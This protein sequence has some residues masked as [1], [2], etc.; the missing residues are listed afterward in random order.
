M[1]KNFLFLLVLMHP[2]FIHCAASEEL[3]LSHNPEEH[4]SLDGGV[5]EF[6]SFEAPAKETE[7]TKDEE[8]SA[9]EQCN[10]LHEL[11][12]DCLCS[13]AEFLSD[14]SLQAFE[15][16]HKRAKEI[17][18][19]ARLTFYRSLTPAA[20]SLHFTT[21][22]LGDNLRKIKLLLQSGIDP[23]TAN[24]HGLNVMMFAINCNSRMAVAAMI[25]AG[26]NVNYRNAWGFTPLMCSICIKCKDVIGI[27]LGAGADV[28]VPDN[29]GSSPIFYAIE[30][31]DNEVVKMLIDAGADV[32]FCSPATR[33]TSL[34]VAAKA[35][36]ADIVR[37]L[38]DCRV[39]VDLQ[40]SDGNTALIFAA[41][42]GS[43][44]IVRQLI[45]V[46]A[47]L[48]IQNHQ[49]RTALMQ[50]SCW[51]NEEMVSLLIDAGADPTLV[52]IDG[53]SAQ[54]LEQFSGYDDIVF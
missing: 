47:N 13:I 9:V 33:M 44:L 37:A 23:D 21:A 32:N 18:Y 14:K 20:R 27:L 36:H 42:N 15:N 49:G 50:V 26:A 19:T 3:Y 39:P 5:P 48:N 43:K 8:R 10:I 54:E 41:S 12:D 53:R 30:N 40:D 22:V 6:K 28:N 4:Q 24:A 45:D 2:I 34:M 17:G 38:L 35:N 16:S 1:K 52:D 46:G 11:P 7:E 51:G 31:G 25:E 29:Q